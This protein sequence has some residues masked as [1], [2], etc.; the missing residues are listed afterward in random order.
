MGAGVK[1]GEFQRRKG[2]AG[3]PD[4]SADRVIR[5]AHQK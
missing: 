4:E 3:G 5:S 1:I 2:A